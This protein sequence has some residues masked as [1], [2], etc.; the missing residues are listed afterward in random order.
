MA[1]LKLDLRPVLR[2]LGA[3]IQDENADRLLGGQDVRG[4]ELE[5][6]KEL[7]EEA[8]GRKRIRVLGIRVAVRELVRL[9]VKTGEMLKDLTRRGNVKVGRTSLKIVPSA[10]TR[11]RW[12][13]FNKG[14]EGKQPARPVGGI[15]AA[16]LA[17]AAAEVARAAREQLVVALSNREKKPT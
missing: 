13:V 12:I 2:A 9:G 14:R 11:L 7:A 17:E 16:R 5:P 8:K 4:N 1:K 15:A 6:A 10:K 3:R